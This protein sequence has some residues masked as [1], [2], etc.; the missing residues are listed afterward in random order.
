MAVVS[1]CNGSG[2]SFASVAAYSA[3]SSKERW[4]LMRRL[5]DFEGLAIFAKVAQLQSFA[6]AA[7]ELSL[8]KGTVSKAVS[9]LESRLKVRLFNRTSRRLALTETGTQLAGRASDLLA[10]CEAAEDSV[11]GQA[12]APRGAIRL[13]APVSFGVLYIAPLLPEFFTLYPE[14]TVDLQM[15][16]SITD[17]IGEGFDAAIRIAT[18]PDS[19][20]IAR[21]LFA[22]PRYLVGAP[23]YFQKH[24][25]PRHPLQLA[26]HQCIVHVRG[27]HSEPWHFTSK[28]GETASI[29]PT[30]LLRTNN[31]DATLPTLRAGLALGI[32]PEFFVREDLV[33]GV[34]ERILPEWTL[35]AGAVHWVTPARGLRPKRVDI[36][37]E[38]LAE[39]LARGPA[40]KGRGR[41]HPPT[42]G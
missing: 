27:T 29:R 13:A 31:G 14:I 11:L 28:S 26:E 35:R 23:G 9:R 2:P 12:V 40:K 24:G 7:A 37:G 17:L 22:M 8:S 1:S 18:L 6:A 36:L 5:P 38:F 34:L 21:T 41:Q 30:G 16:D 20:M 25:K 19:S 15:D 10:E 4:V 39:K 33:S 42:G 32:L 3:P